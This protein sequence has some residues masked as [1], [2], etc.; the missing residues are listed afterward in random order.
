MANTEEEFLDLIDQHQKLIHNVCRMYTGN[1]DDHQDLFQEIMVQLWKG[2]ANFEKR[3]KVSTW[4]YRVSLYTAISHIKRVIKQREAQPH[5]DLDLDYEQPSLESD[6]AP[7]QEAI[8]RLD[9][10]DRAIVLL[11][12]DEKSYKEMAEILGISDSNVGV[13]LNRV[14]KKLKTL[15]IS[16]K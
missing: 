8:E 7:L 2:Y 5:L 11:H 4:M 14:K 12:L 15:L 1:V 16:E 10:G 9:D 13:R 3:S 6:S